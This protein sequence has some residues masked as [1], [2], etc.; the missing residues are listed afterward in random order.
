MIVTEQV[1]RGIATTSPTS[2]KELLAV[3][4]IGPKK[5]ERYGEQL[6]EV[7]RSHLLRQRTSPQDGYDLEL[8]E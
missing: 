7:V 1:M 5:L 8:P 4:G 6:L 3:K 2:T